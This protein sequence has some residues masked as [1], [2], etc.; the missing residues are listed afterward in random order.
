MN[1]N[2]LKAIM[3]THND[4][5]DSLAKELNVTRTTLYSK[6][7]GKSQFTL[8]D[9]QTIKARYNLTIEEIGNIFFS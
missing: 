2:L 5:I 4:K 3:L 7:K 8:R 9:I 1:K 6:L